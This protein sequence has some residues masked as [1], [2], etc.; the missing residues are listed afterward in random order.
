MS[1]T[2][3]QRLVPVPPPG[4]INTGSSPCPTTW[5]IAR[6][7]R[8]RTLMTQVCLPVTSPFWKARMV[9]ADVG[10]FRVTGHRKA[11]ELLRGSLA[12]VKARRPVLY[13]V[14]GTAGMLCCRNVRGASVPSN[15]AL[16]LAIDFTID[17]EIDRRG[18]GL[19]LAG[20]L[21]LYSVL[22]EDGWF[23]GAEFRVE[24]SMHF[25]VSSEVVRGWIAEG[26]F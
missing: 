2:D 9:T 21:D 19:C 23:W 20:L 12:K 7:G 26:V 16:G 3:L 18:D 15:H 24:D 22:K 14:L 4:S 13:A 5:L 11:V 10:V 8:P 25:E 1:L 17:G 6:Y